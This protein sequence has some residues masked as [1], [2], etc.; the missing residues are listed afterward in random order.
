[1]PIDH[2]TGLPI[3]DAPDCFDYDR[4]KDIIANIKLSYSAT[5]TIP[6]PNH[7]ALSHWSLPS[8]LPPTCT[9]TSTPNTTPSKALALALPPSTLLI[10]VEGILLYNCQALLP[11]FDVRI[12][13][14]ASKNLCKTRRSDRNT[15]LSLA[16]LDPLQ[17]LELDD[18]PIFHESPLYF[19]A[20]VW[21]NYLR[22]SPFA[23]HNPV[24]SLYPITTI[25]VDSI[26][27]HQLINSAS[28]LINAHIQ[29][30]S[31]PQ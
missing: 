16:P 3:W 5:K 30:L 6:K 27:H 21:P 12:F 9:S 8:T 28:S 23:D 29:S 15:Q 26:S 31:L 19:D 10:I 2:S 25:D 13:L 20:I 17:L 7:S 22:F 24:S 1:M 4:L 14:L 18:Q 11:L